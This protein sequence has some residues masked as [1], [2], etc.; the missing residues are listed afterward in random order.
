MTAPPQ[1]SELLSRIAHHEVR[2]VVIGSVAAALHGAGQIS[3]GDLDVTPALDR[4]NLVRLCALL[5]EV[6]ATLP[7]GPGGHWERDPRGER[8][9]IS[10]GDPTPEELQRRATWTPDPDRPAELD[11][12]FW[13]RLGNF[14]VVPDLVG[15]YDALVRRAVVVPVD[16]RPV[17][18]AHVDDLLSALTI[19]RREKDR[20]RVQAL[21]ETQRGDR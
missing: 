1:V 15:T 6:E 3:P 7:D 9:W 21:R 11:S 8:R 2:V 12:L 17:R 4:P 18:V 13:T 5:R 20:S 14:D 19:P 10:H 16:G